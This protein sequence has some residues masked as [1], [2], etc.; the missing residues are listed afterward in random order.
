M[1][2][3]TPGGPMPGAWRSVLRSGGTRLLVLPVSALLGIVVTRLLVDTYGTAVYAQYALL[4]TLGALLPFTDLGMSAAVMNAVGGSPAPDR[5]DH[6][7]RTITTALRV[8]VASAAVLALVTLLV[9]LVGLWPTLLGGGLL[10]GSGPAVAAG[11]V[12]LIA[13]GIPV[14]I[15]Q[16]M[17]VGL[18]QNHV[19]ILV[20]GLQTPVVLGVLALF[21]AAGIPAGAAFPVV[22]Y[23]VTLV[24]AGV[25]T[26]L[27]AR[28]LRP[29]LGQ[30]VRRVPRLR[31][32]RGAPVLG[33]AWPM[34]VQLV[35]VPL[36]MQSDRLLLSH[37]RGP[38][39]LAEYSLASQMFV[40]IWALVNSAGLA[41]WPVFARARAQRA[42][43][44]P[45]SMALAFA[46][47][48][49]V[50]A[51]GVAVLSPWLAELASGGAVQLGGALVVGFAVL[52]VVQALKYPLGIYLT[53]APGLR[54]QAGMVVA[55]LPVNVALSWWLADRMG[56]A[57]PV[58]GSVVAVLLFEVLANALQVRRRLRRTAGP[59]H[60]ADDAP[61]E[62]VAR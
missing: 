43:A 57:G 55:M 56:A 27:A 14:G 20:L 54:F 28:R 31:T 10:D 13:L 23:A 8:L 16:R 52:M 11:C 45:W 1:D 50:L 37:L 36:A 33:V 25:C 41:L 32:E 34:L 12:L 42:T 3:T 5:D 59:A 39:E 21:V 17:L 30:A 7:R 26:W 38:A 35:A 61:A 15:G 48:G 60:P 18:G 22:P 40:P 53:D 24:L 2:G 44:A 6:V 4:V 49:A 62:L 58:L 9:S 29:I 46:G 51:T 47:V 19:S